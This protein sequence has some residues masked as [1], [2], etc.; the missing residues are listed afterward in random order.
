MKLPMKQLLEISNNIAITA[1][2]I[3]IFT[4]LSIIF[5][6]GES[7]HKYIKTIRTLSS[8]C[9]VSA[10]IFLI[11]MIYGQ[12]ITNSISSQTHYTA[13]NIPVK[14]WVRL[15]T[16]DYKVLTTNNKIITISNDEDKTKINIDTSLKNDKP[17]ASLTKYSATNR[18]Y[19][20][21]LDTDTIPTEYYTL[22]IHEPY[23]DATNNN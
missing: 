3:S 16:G 19:L 12:K 17:H 10:C 1:F 5:I 23:K 8:I 22:T 15:E 7:D 20:R 21:Q 18:N 6:V 13:T 14:R 9:V 4:I 2:T 11:A